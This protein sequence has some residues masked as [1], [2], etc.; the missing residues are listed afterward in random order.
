MRLPFVDKLPFIG[1]LV[2]DVMDGTIPIVIAPKAGSDALPVVVE[3]KVAAATI[4]TAAAT[5]VLALLG[6]LL[7][8]LPAPLRAIVTLAL[9]PLVTA[10][11][12]WLA[13]HTPRPVP[14]VPVAV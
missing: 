13:P 10:A 1:T 5:V 9:P 8:R 7:A 6:P 12:G 2:N 14:P 4:A 3:A 11:V